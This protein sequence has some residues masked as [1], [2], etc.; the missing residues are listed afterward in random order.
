MPKRSENAIPKPK[1]RRNSLVIYGNFGNKR[2]FVFGNWADP[3]AWVRYEA[4][5]STGLLPTKPTPESSNGGVNSENGTLNSTRGISENLHENFTENSLC[6]SPV[7]R[8]LE[9]RAEMAILGKNSSSP[10]GEFGSPRCHSSSP[11]GQ[12]AGDFPSARPTVKALVS[13][14]LDYVKRDYSQ[15][16]Y[17]DYRSIFRNW[18]L[19]KD[20]GFAELPVDNFSSQH[21]LA[22][23]DKMVSSGRV[24]RDK[25]NHFKNRIV[26]MFDWGWSVGIVTHSDL[27]MR[28]K[29]IRPL[30]KG[31]RGT[32][33]HP[34]RQAVSL[35]VVRRTL[36]WLSPT[37]GTMV[38]L[39]YLLGSRPNEIFNMRVGEVDTTRGN[40]LWYYIPGSYKTAKHV[41]TNQ[42]L[43]PKRFVH[44]K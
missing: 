4:Y 38:M 13:A 18:L 22:I 37:V 23:R 8:L 34:P 40:G 9:N 42:S 25:I 6:G 1:K 28:L 17:D 24:C 26:F 30:R 33:D 5:L 3:V 35:D 2:Y 11:T 19:S 44:R 32:F 15:K 7:R 12:N 27:I 43:Y 31:A 41:K 20:L 16:Q 39:Q 21:M 14:F 36:P 29:A 10:K